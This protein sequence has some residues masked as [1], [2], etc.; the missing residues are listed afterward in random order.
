MKTTQKLAGLPL[1]NASSANEVLSQLHQLV[2]TQGE[3]TTRTKPQ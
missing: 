1:E 3:A 2:P